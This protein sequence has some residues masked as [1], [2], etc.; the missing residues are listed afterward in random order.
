MEEIGLEAVFKDEGFNKGVTGYQNSVEAASTKTGKFSG[1]MSAIGGA[2]KIGVMGVM[3]IAT[4][5]VGVVA[6]LGSLVMKASDT[7]GELVDLSLKT[8]IGVETLQEMKYVGEQTGT[9]LEAITG[10]M[11]KLKRAMGDV[12]TNKAVA[13]NFEK[14]GVSVY[15][16]NGNLR[17][18]E[19]VFND[20]IAAL[21]KMTNET[22]RD[23]LAMDIFGRSAVE[24]NPLIKTGAEGIAALTAEA[25]TMGAVM[26]EDAVYGLEGFGD[27]IASLKAGFQGIVGQIGSAVLP[28]FVEL[29]DKLLAFVKSPEFQAGIQN[30]IKWLSEY[31]PIAIQVLSDF[32]TN[33]LVPAI[34]Y[35]WEFIGEFMSVVSAWW[36]EHGAT[37]IAT[38][39][40]IWKV[41][42]AIYERARDTIQNIVAL[43]HLAQAG[44]WEGFGVK[45]REIVDRLWKEVKI[46]FKNAIDAVIKFFTETDWK[47]VGLNII[48]GI[49]NGITSG[50]SWIINAAKAAAQAAFDAVKGFL[51]IDSPSKVFMVIGANMMQGMAEGILGTAQLPAMAM[52]ASTPIPNSNYSVSNSR[53]NNVNI[54]MGGVNI[55]NGANHQA[56]ISQVEWAVQRALGV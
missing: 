54:N 42:T 22:E 39:E 6:G 30:L 12:G 37:V 51:G 27:S 17:D 56:F 24:L 25:R 40:G 36:K 53:T 26:G 50:V 19:D 32:F 2:A 3:G 35:V 33:V 16:A 49:A 1:A 44:D 52:A 21:G 13:E 23:S 11:T 5:A 47:Q 38:I 28:I 31:L 18:S 20:T 10:S 29:V 14:L 9:S 15:D 55:H 46:I 8:G 45:I 48:Q 34:Q 7:A 4:A 41:I 43:F